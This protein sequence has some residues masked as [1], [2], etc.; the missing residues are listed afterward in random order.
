[1]TQTQAKIPVFKRFSLC[2]LNSVVEILSRQVLVLF[3]LFR[4]N[5]NRRHSDRSTNQHFR[6]IQRIISITLDFGSD[7]T[8]FSLASVCSIASMT[9]TAHLSLRLF[10]TFVSEEF[11]ICAQL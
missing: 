2:N 11:V 8:T 4:K 1:M 10:G 3:L 6:N 9:V 7:N 5:D